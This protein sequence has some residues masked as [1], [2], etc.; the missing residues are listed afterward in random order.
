MSNPAPYAG[1]SSPGPGP[2]GRL[3]L[4]G[5]AERARMAGGTLS[6]A[7]QDGHFV[8]DVRLPWEA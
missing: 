1:S 8:L 5:L 7:V 2:G 6:H 4:V 3:G